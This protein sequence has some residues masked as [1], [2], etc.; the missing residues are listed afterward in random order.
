MPVDE[1]RAHPRSLSAQFGTAEFPFHIDTAHWVQPC[2]YVLMGAP[3][4]DKSKRPTELLDFA[5]LPIAADE[6]RALSEGIYLVAAGRKSFYA[7]AY[8][9]DR[10]FVRLDPGCMKPINDQARRS[11]D[12]LT[13]EYFSEMAVKVHWAG[14]T[15]LVLDNWRMLHRRAASANE[16]G[17]RCLFRALAQ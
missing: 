7:S 8:A 1:R 15:V 10:P 17:S 14:G 9:N 12:L 6:R 11:M 4:S 5:Q 16:A 2:R 3:E 13:S